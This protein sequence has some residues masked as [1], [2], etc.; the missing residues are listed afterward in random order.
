MQRIV[1]PLFL[2]HSDAVF[3]ERVRRASQQRFS[4]R[5]APT[6]T[7]LRD[8]IRQSPPG[9]IV[10]VDPYTETGI[11][12]DLSPA[13]HALLLDFPSATVIAALNVRRR[14]FR[15]VHT[16]CAWGVADIICLGEDDTAE[17]IGHMLLS[18]SGFRLQSLLDAPLPSHMPGRARS[19]LLVAADMVS[20][21]GQAEDLARALGVNRRTL[22]RWCE[23]AGLPPPRRLM[24]WMRILL[25]AEMLDEP[26][27]TVGSIAFACGY[28][29]DTALR[30]ALQM[31]L[32]KA[33]KV[34]R[35]EGAFAAASEAFGRELRQVQSR[36]KT[37]CAGEAAAKDLSG[38]FS[39]HSA[40]PQH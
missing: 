36:V 31:Q 6:W 32:G 35:R 19:I 9:A 40:A 2:L 28:A 4:F 13:L 8:E 18:I 25:A 24:A 7:D 14:D 1:R 5:E 11:N 30:T 33:P 21:G 10:I 22:L 29:S 37:S 3:R 17:S 39:P 23:Q 16:M 26:G 15:K 34:L 38:S 27:R 20:A 12:G